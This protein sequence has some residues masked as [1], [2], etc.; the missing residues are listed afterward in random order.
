MK[1]EVMCSTGAGDWEDSIE[2]I[3][4]KLELM[5]SMGATVWKYRIGAK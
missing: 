2:A 1:M 4:R 5:C 3:K